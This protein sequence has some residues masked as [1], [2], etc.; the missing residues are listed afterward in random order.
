MKR[1]LYLASFL[2]ATAIFAIGCE[3]GNDTPSPTPTDAA[4]DTTPVETGRPDLG[5]TDTGVTDT[6]VTD[7]GATDTGPTDTG[8]TDA[9][10]TD[11]GPTD[12]GPTDTGPA[13]TG[14]ETAVPPAPP[15]LGTVIDR[16]GRPAINT[17]T[18][19]AFDANATTKNAAKDAYNQ[20]AQS[21]WPTFVPE[22]EANLAILDAL[23]G[24]CG[25][26]AFA[27]KTKTD[28]TR[29]G[30]LATVLADDRL[31]LK[32]DATTCTTYL[33]VEA[34]AT[35]LVTNTDCGGRKPGYDV[36]EE[37]YSLVAAGAL[38]GVSDGVTPRSPATTTFP[39]LDAPHP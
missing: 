17:A 20:A 28:A 38:S 7:T 39:Y 8:V 4:A 14:A 35:G 33:A 11:T 22:I 37:T 1:T 3:G 6:G 19:H 36:M 12:T 13:D 24:V 32:T 9:G 5:T 18:N 27:D 34:N 21:T 25:N 16:M 15:T 26:Q 2:A 30:T 10:P 23:D 29:Y 31:W